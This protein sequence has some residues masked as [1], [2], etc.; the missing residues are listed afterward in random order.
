MLKFYT[1]SAQDDVIDV[2]D[3]YLTDLFAKTYRKEQKER[4][5]TIKD[6]DKAAR[7]L[8]EACVTLLEHTDPSV[9]PKTA[10]FEKI[11]E[12]DLI[13]AVQIVDSLTYSPNQTLAYSGLLQ[14]YGTIRK[15]LPLL[16][17][18]IELQAT[19]AGLPI[20]QA[21][22]FVKEHGKSNKKRWK[23]APLVGLNANWSKVVIDKDSGTV[24]H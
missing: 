3:R 6:L 13:Q 19:P 23:N 15:F 4:L 18:E 2:L 14:Y 12:K 17:E 1:Q 9:H 20:L 8:R 24:N 21:W 5:R 10:V 7:Q 16:M 11:S 22:N